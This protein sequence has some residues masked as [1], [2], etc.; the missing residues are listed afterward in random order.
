[1]RNI[2]DKHFSQR[3]AALLIV[4]F[5]GL[6]P[7]WAF[8]FSSVC[9]SGQSLYYEVIDE[10]HV[11]VV[12][13]GNSPWVGYEKPT[14][15][16]V[17]PYDVDGKV[18]SEIQEYAFYG[19]SEITQ[20]TIPEGITRVGDFAFWN[21]PELARVNFNAVHCDYMQSN[22][23]DELFDEGGISSVFTSAGFE[24]DFGTSYYSPVTRIVIGSNVQ[25]IPSYAFYGVENAYYRM[26]IPN[27]VI[28][29]GDHA[30][31]S[32]KNLPSMTI[33]N[34]VTTIGDWAFHGCSGLTGSLVIPNSVTTIG[35]RAFHGCSGLTGS[36]V[37]PNSVTTIGDWAFHGCSGLTGSLTIG[38]SVTDIGGSA[39]QGCSNCFD[40][41]IVAAD[42]TAFDSRENCNALVNSFTDELL[43]GCKNSVIPNSVK[44]I[45]Y[46]AFHGCSGLT[47]SLVIP[48]SVTT[49]GDHAFEGCSGLT[50]S[51]T[52][53]NSV[54][55]IAQSAFQ[56][57]SG[58]T[59]LT[60]GNSVKTIGHDAFLGCSG[61]TGSL[62]IP[63]S[64]TAIYDNAFFGCSGVTS[65]TI[66]ESVT[67]IG[68]QAFSGCSNLT[69]VLIIPQSVSFIG[70]YAFENCIGFTAL[71]SE[72]LMPPGYYSEDYDP[73]LI[74]EGIFEGM[75]INI[76]FYVPYG[77]MGVY[78]S[79]DG[80]SQF[81]NRIEQKLF[82]AYYDD[83][84]DW[85]DDLNWYTG[86]LP[87][88]ND[89]VCLN[90]NCQLDTDA[91]VLYAYTR[92]N[93]DV[94][95]V[96]V[97]HTLTSTYGV[98]TKDAS[99]LVIEDDGQLVSMG[100]NTNGTLQ[101]QIAGYGTGNDGWF[102]IA[103]PIY[104]GM[105][106]SSLTTGEYDLYAYDEPTAMW[107]NHKVSSN[108]FTT[109][110]LAQGYLYASQ[111]GRTAN[112]AGRLNASNAEISIP[113]TYTS[114]EL[115]GFNLVGN[116]YTNSISV[117]DV[118]INGTTQTAFYRAEGGSSFVAW[119]AEDNEPIKPGQGFFVKAAEEGTLT[120]GSTPNRGEE[121]RE[122]RY[123]RLVLSKD[124]QVADRAYLR[125]NEGQTMEKFGTPTAHS[126]LY[127]MNG[128]ERY[129]VVA[130][131][132]EDGVIPLYLEN[133]NG[134]YTL[135]ASQL[136]IECS[137]LHLIDN[138]T[139]ADIDL[140]E[141]SSYTF[142]AKPSDYASRFDLVF[143]VGSVF[144]DEDGDN[145][146][147]AYYNGSE[148]V[149]VNNDNA[150][151]QI[152]DV[153][154]HIVYCREAVHNVSIRDMASGIY[155][156]RLVSGENVKTQ[157]IFIK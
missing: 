50:G 102:T 91:Q 22:W 20:V 150:T 55:Y 32:C 52:I 74:T 27:S 42:N 41:I 46:C 40:E 63:N 136:N 38:N 128:G 90:S 116:P 43:L 17:I 31:C 79:Y 138:L 122:N 69:G 57:C 9:S 70:Q 130:N 58:V 142:T 33:G 109:L 72:C 30:F 26:V 51:L 98:G 12:Y 124:G 152:V 148:W 105:S 75:N 134:N 11:K 115:A 145:E 108:N 107:I 86:E 129:A 114:G 34:S 97:G 88:A 71:I 73:S 151:L 103:T 95:T 60:I 29:I 61:L 18:V 80:W 156:M 87:T 76:P 54:T 117:T 45:G 24:P 62:V 4:F 123:V 49:I 10:S 14:G 68:Y 112:F 111:T 154:G 13:P 155:M 94:L 21:C 118:K 133:A 126:Q 100:G 83:E 6:A 15:N 149:V 64:V 67:F 77:K 147:F 59:S 157:K 35:Y 132:A 120:F 85:S 92:L 7:A 2:Y 93:T 89:V 78:A 39:F 1:M 153:V 106:V 137:Y 131:E 3:F 99:Q 82:E 44:T 96:G 36:L 47:G 16:L 28:T 143:K 5:F 127:F 56:G 37:I 65:L 81:T 141:T 144:G 146:D 119:V 23:Y 121:Q 66:G 125:M 48:N 135:E 140:L 101:K 104:D 110:N 113:V 84:M 53:G 8:D 139:G 19:C 25:Y